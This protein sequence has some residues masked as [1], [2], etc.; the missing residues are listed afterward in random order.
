MADGG[1]AQ[2]AAPG[3]AAPA[4]RPRAVAFGEWLDEDERR[5]MRPAPK[6]RRGVQR[7]APQPAAA[8]AAEPAAS[9]RR[10]QP[11]S[12]FAGAGVLGGMAKK[13]RLQQQQQERGAA[14]DGALPQRRMRHEFSPVVRQRW[15]AR[16]NAFRRAGAKNCYAEAVRILDPN[17]RE[18]MSRQWC[19]PRPVRRCVQHVPL[20][21]W[22]V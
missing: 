1:A 2:A 15:V 14:A 11:V 3:V 16:A 18:Q 20:M 4:R 17:Y 5:F 6:K 9:R 10:A 21:A 19:A 12:I 7:A 22:R 13:A 8:A